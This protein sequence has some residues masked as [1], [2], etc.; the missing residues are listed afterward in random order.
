[1]S[2]TS[3][4][5]ALTA[6]R[7]VVIGELLRTAELAS[8]IGT[9]SLH[10]RI[11]EQLVTKLRAN[12]FHL[13]VVGEFNHGKSSLVNA[14]LG[15]AVLHVGVTPTTATIHQLS[16]GDEPSAVVVREDGSETSVAF[17]SLADYAADGE[18]AT[19]VEEGASIRHV[20]V[21]YPSELLREGIILIDTPGVNDLCLQRADITYEYIPHS[22]AV[23]FVLDAGQPL[24]ESERV[25][26]KEKLLAK[27]RDK[28]IFVVCKADI[29]SEDERGEAMGYIR[30]ELGKLVD[31]PTVFAVSAQ[32][33]LAGEAESSGMVEL[34]GHL[35]T[36]LAEER[37]RI[38]LDNALGEALG[39][40]QTLSH[41]LDA[42][43]RAAQMSAEEIARRIVVIEDDLAGHR[44]TL[45]ERRSAIRAEVAAIKAWLRRD[46]D[47]FSDDVVRQLPAAVELASADELRR[48]W[49]GF[50]ESTFASWAN[51]Q[52]TEVASALEKLAD[53]TVALMREDA[54]DA[55]ARLSSGV[56]AD[57]PPPDIQ[58][59]TFAYDLSVAALFSVGMG[60]VF[61]NV[62]LGVVMAGAAPALA[63]YL[64]GKI[65]IQTRDKAQQQAALAVHE[66]VSAVSPKL[67]QMIDDFAERLDRWM[68]ETGRELHCELLDV[69]RSCQVKRREGEADEATLEAECDRVAGELTAQRGRF[70]RIRG[71][72][73]GA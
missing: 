50:L 35:T 7:D 30:D 67:D 70:E 18:G 53:K 41:A 26:L 5:Q 25:F 19:P 49:V 16:H 9:C 27:S 71:E 60:M 4:F 46:L 6:R 10:D 73:W 59:D 65:E 40:C 3:P 54:H 1:M 34:L 58:V 36:F 8:E 23:L 72:L 2:D 13:V 69:L 52:S 11:E 15:E 17:S 32:R 12:R 55:A 24:K 44:Q 61:S 20:A 22:D 57:L 38:A 51:E 66:A 47:R 63:Y 45:G 37:G 29:W 28:I 39:V 56:G 64:K 31:S 43:R 21:S 33:A 62:L 68:I 42:R 48:H 14:L